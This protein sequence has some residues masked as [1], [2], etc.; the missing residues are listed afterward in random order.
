[1]RIRSITKPLE[2]FC[3]A[4]LR[5]CRAFH[6]VCLPGLPDGPA[7][8]HLHV[9]YL[10]RCFGQVRK[11]RHTSQWNLSPC[12]VLV[13]CFNDFRN[14]LTGLA[15]D[16][17]GHHAA[18]L[19][20]LLEHRPA[21][22]CQLSRQLFNIARPGSG[23]TDTAKPA[24]FEKQGLDIARHAP[25]KPVRQAERMG[26]RQHRHAVCAS[27]TGGKGSRCYPQHVHV[28][29]A[30]AHHAGGGFDMKGE[31]RLLEAACV[32]HTRPHLADG[33]QLGH[34]QELVGICRHQHGDVR[35]GRCGFDPASSSRRI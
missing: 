28:R 17:P 6:H 22:R 30:L 5:Q 25:R 14:C 1:M 15:V 3:K 35:R 13:A 21:C 4:V 34:G 24:F 33:A 27:N 2:W 31:R 10:D 29:V 7:L 19:F 20:D 23:I 26:K 9:E 32:K 18:R 12:D 16:K 8:R 11:L